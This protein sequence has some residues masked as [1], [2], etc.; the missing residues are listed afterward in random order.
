MYQRKQSFENHSTHSESRDKILEILSTDP[1]NLLLVIVSQICDVTITDN[2]TYRYYSI[3]QSYTNKAYTKIQDKKVKLLLKLWFKEL[4]HKISGRIIIFPEDQKIIDRML[5]KLFNKLK[6][7]TPNQQI[8]HTLFNKFREIILKSDVNLEL[9][10][11]FQSHAVNILNL[12]TYTSEITS[13][14]TS[15]MNNPDAT[16]LVACHGIT[17]M[18]S[19]DYTNIPISQKI[20]YLYQHIMKIPPINLKTA[21]NLFPKQHIVFSIQNKLLY[22]R[23]ELKNHQNKTEKFLRHQ[24]PWYSLTN[25]INQIIHTYIIKPRIMKK[26]EILKRIEYAFTESVAYGD[27]VFFFKQLQVIRQDTNISWNPYY[28][29]IKI[30]VRSLNDMTPCTQNIM[31]TKEFIGNIKVYTEYEHAIHH[32]KNNKREQII[33]ENNKPHKS[34][35][36]KKTKK[37]LKHTK[38]IAKKTTKSLKS[39]IR[40]I[41]HNKPKNTLE[42]LPTP[43]TSFM[44]IDPTSFIKSTHTH[45]NPSIYKKM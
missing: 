35:I 20:S 10:E 14:I 31:T 11:F 8:K 5:N 45:P 3:I 12:T 1:L 19:K 40:K 13:E 34:N 7:I 38:H 21:L 32:I 42:T 27:T 26:I 44:S 9:K 28:K 15:A 37:V 41:I 22:R 18:H 39:K 17:K 30:L 25:K 36:I 43:S 24:Y 23:I 33:P 6:N 16:L 4:I 2:E 29:D